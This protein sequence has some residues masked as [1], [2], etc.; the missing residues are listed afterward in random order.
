M[1]ITQELVTEC[2]IPIWNMK[3][4]SLPHFI[5]TKGQ[6]RIPHAQPS[7]EQRKLQR[8]SAVQAAIAL[9]QD[10][11]QA[12]EE[13]QATVKRLSE[14]HGKPETFIPEQLHLGGAV[15]K[16]RRT[17][18]INNAFAH[19]EAQCEDECELTTAL[20]EWDTYWHVLLGKHDDSKAHIC[21]IVAKAQ[22]LGSYEHLEEG[23]KDLL[24]EALEESRAE[25]DTGIVRR[26]L[27][28]MHNV[29]AV[30]SRVCREVSW[31]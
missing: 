15:L 28:Q 31:I 16:Q 25:I 13:L 3:T 18:G 22:E 23:E 30:C 17:P 5:M 7:E 2:G 19:C 4:Y 6:S 11:N 26:P 20:I 9:Q 14:K 24:K 29:W 10:I 21:L 12:L 8:D 1:A 27:A